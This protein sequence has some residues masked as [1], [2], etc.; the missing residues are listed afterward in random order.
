MIKKI[1][2]LLILTACSPSKQDSSENIKNYNAVSDSL[3]KYKR[4]IKSISGIMP[5]VLSDFMQLD[6]AEYKLKYKLSDT[7]MTKLCKNYTVT[8]QLGRNKRDIDANVTEINTL[9]I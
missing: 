7:E 3:V 4:E 5:P 9:E 1:Q 8:Y 6:Y 2:L